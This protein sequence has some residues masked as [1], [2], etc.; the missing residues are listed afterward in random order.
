M[1]AARFMEEKNIK[2]V[3]FGG[4]PLG[5]PVLEELKAAGL[6]P[7]LIVCNPDRPVGR[8]QLLTPP[9]VKIWAE[10]HSIEV[11]QPESF[12]KDEII[13]VGPLYDIE[14]DVFVVVAYNKILPKWF[15][16]LPK[17]G[18]VNVHPSLLPLLRGAS[19]IRSTILEDMKDMCGVSVMQLD[20]KMDHGPLL[21]QERLQISDNAWPIK[22]CELD[23]ALARLGGSLLAAA[24]PDYVAGN[25]TPQEQNHDAATYCGKL[26]RSMGELQIDPYN[27]PT[28]NEA[29]QALLKIRAFD[30]FPGTFFIHDGKRIKITDA[31]L[32]AGKLRI[33]RIIPEGKKEVDFNQYY[34]I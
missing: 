11:W 16:E 3:Y 12:K 31:E 4:E 27:L 20:E 1:L 2:F 28:G 5:V 29:Y 34:S 15:I 8:K 22:G 7:S 19:P 18:S 10:A 25:I 9:P 14:W 24:L 32:A 13:G 17:H 21:A 23:E 33:L 6:L 30:G 26:D